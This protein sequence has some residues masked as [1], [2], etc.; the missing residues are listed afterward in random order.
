MSHLFCTFPHH[1]FECN[2]NIFAS[3][4]SF[5]KR[6]LKNSIVFMR[7]FK[8]GIIKTLTIV[9]FAFQICQVLSEC[10][11]EREFTYNDGSCIPDADK[12]NKEEDCPGGE[13][14]EDCGK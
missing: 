4:N 11:P 14:E 9:L 7:L 12:C 2:L 1:T 10:D 6:S 5:E 3:L 13:D 8:M